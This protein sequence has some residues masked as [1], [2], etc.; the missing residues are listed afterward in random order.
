MRT[1]AVHC[2]HRLQTLH[3]L[4]H[5]LPTRTKPGSV[6]ALMEACRT[7]SVGAVVPSL[8]GK[9]CITHAEGGV[10]HAGGV[11]HSC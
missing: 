9:R 3:H 8:L 4:C 11:Y 10:I 6:Q 5:H 1:Q 7:V 2:H